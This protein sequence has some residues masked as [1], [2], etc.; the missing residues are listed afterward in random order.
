MKLD[1]TNGVNWNRGAG[2]DPSPYSGWFTIIGM[3]IMILCL[4]VIHWQDIFKG[5]G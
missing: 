4:T 5:G 3:A 2:R 1:W